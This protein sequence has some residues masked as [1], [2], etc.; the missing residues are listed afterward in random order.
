MFIRMTTLT[1][2]TT[3]A[4]RSETVHKLDGLARR[5]RTNRSE[6]LR[7]IIDLADEEE[8]VKERFA[9]LE[10]LEAMQGLPESSKAAWSAYQSELP[11]LRLA[12]D[13]QRGF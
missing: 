2:R 3:Y 5:W 12:D 6:A 11:D 7:R 4:L 10:A 1:I 8:R 13:A 9:P